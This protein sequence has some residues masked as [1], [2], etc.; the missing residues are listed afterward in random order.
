MPISHINIY[1]SRARIE[2]S[3]PFPF[4]GAF[5]RATATP[6]I[7]R[8]S[9]RH[10]ISRSADIA[11]YDFR[12][13]FPNFFFVFCSSVAQTNFDK[14][15]PMALMWCTYWRIVGCCS[16]GKRFGSPVASP[17]ALTCIYLET[18]SVQPEQVFGVQTTIKN[19]FKLNSN[20]GQT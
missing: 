15:I 10:R 19:H 5:G 16:F 13:F 1:A 3:L 9:L 8:T 20:N 11:W 17:L 18:S 4:Y 6:S 7:P 14:L 2:K 12:N